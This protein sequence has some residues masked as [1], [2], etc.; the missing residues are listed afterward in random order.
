MF[1]IVSAGGC[2][3]APAVTASSSPTTA[4][5][6]SVP[7]LYARLPT[8]SAESPDDI[9][10]TPGDDTY[11]ANVHEQGIPDKWPTIQTVSERLAG[12]TDTIL[13]RYRNSITTNAGEIRNNLLNISKENGRFDSQGFDVA[14]LYTVGAPK[15]LQF[16]QGSAG[17][18]IGTVAT[19]LVIEIPEGFEPG[20]YEF[21]IGVGVEG[22]DYGTLPCT[23][24]VT[25][26]VTT[27]D[28]FATTLKK[29]A[30]ESTSVEIRGFPVG[31]NVM[32]FSN[33]PAYGE[34]L[35]RLAASTIQRVTSK[36]ATVVHNGTT[37]T[38]QVTIPYTLAIMLTFHLTDG[39]EAEFDI[40][41]E[42]VWFETD[43][44]IYQASVSPELYSF[45]RSLVAQ[46]R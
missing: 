22:T 28:D 33:D 34:L 7:V 15:G 14:E 10:S 39:S 23:L 9:V 18:L 35:R 5:R 13:V 21:E 40:T 12:G 46:G 6:V 44:A 27:S 11:R 42:A 4:A 30:Q 29:V 31:V 20:R 19:V 17:G 26:D 37:T 38:A 43:D 36:S 24:E 25:A 41:D 2:N 16:V 32:V 1:L 45:T 3:R 8:N